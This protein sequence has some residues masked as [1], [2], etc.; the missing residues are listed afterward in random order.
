M[1]RRIASRFVL[2]FSV[3]AVASLAGCGASGGRSGFDD[4]SKDAASTDPSPSGT[5]TGDFGNQ[6]PPPSKPAEVAEVFGH[7]PTTLFRLDPQTKAVAKV[8]DFTGCSGVI[9]IALDEASN[10]YATTNP[11]GT[12]DGGLWKVDKATAK[13]TLV[14][15]GKYPNSLS[16]VPKGTLDANAEA[17]VGYNDDQYI[18]IDT[19]TGAITN[20]GTLSSG[21][22]ISSGDIVAV[23][24][25]DD[26]KTPPKAF[27]TVKNSTAK[28]S[29]TNNDCLVEVDAKTGKVVK[30]WGNIE[31]NNVF[32]LA[33]W[34]G[35]VYGF[36]DAGELFE[37][38]FS[39]AQL[40][41]ASIPVPNK[42]A[43]LQFWGAGSSTAAPL[44]PTA[45]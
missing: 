23:K 15:S 35:S 38:T 28:G 9:D 42:P 40:A 36:D 18:R 25:S 19:T 34:G 16:F 45:K 22:L 13:C 43:G 6:P 41:T 31:H 10:L 39:G 11:S 24:G 8:A 1:L 21:D 30:F 3:V 7:S 20:V 29:C 14:K 26:G 4:A 33:F 12:A 2:P 27:L 32:G 5:P 44:V 17:L 37:V